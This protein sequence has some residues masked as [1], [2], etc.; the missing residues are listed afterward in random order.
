MAVEKRAIL[1]QSKASGDVD[2]VSQEWSQADPW[3]CCSNGQIRLA[4]EEWEMPVSSSWMLTDLWKF[5]L[6]GSLS[7]RV[8]KEPDP[9][10]TSF[11]PRAASSQGNSTPKRL[12]FCFSR[13]SNPLRGQEAKSTTPKGNFP[14]GHFHPLPFTICSALSK[15]QE[16]DLCLVI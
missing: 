16:H 3:R 7:S 1:V 9:W 15:E 4:C 13:L 5:I 11:V 8:Q 6:L 14:L 2:S 10:T 12:T